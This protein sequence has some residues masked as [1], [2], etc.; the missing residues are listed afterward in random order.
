MAPVSRYSPL[1]LDV[2]THG[3]TWSPYW[4]AGSPWLCVLVKDVFMTCAR[5]VPSIVVAGRT[6]IL[7]AALP[8]RFGLSHNLF[9]S[10]IIFRVGGGGW[11]SA[12]NISY[13]KQ[14]CLR[15]P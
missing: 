15:N 9:L 11:A 3:A 1:H 8:H 12:A 5:L 14:S 2:I 13:H 6:P 4:P 10:L 7:S